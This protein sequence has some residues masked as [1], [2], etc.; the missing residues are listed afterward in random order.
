LANILVID[1]EA[2][3]VKA[4]EYNL[5]KEGYGVSRA[6]DG[7]NGLRAA[8]EKQPDLIL[9]DLMLP[10]ISGLE[11][12]KTLKADK[13]TASIPIIMLTA[14]GEEMDKVVGLE[15]GAEDYI[16]KPF[17]MRE[18]IARIK[19]V[20]KRSGRPA[21]TG[22]KLLKS[23]G[24]EL[25]SEK[26]LIS[27]AGKPVELTAK[28]FTLLQFLMESPDK[29]FGRELLLDRVWGIDQSIETRTVDVHMLRLRE[30]LGKPGKALQTIR[31]VGY[32]F[33][34]GK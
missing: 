26:H 20:L 1:D 12:C 3:I 30:K 31:G 17:G 11:L 25:D 9:L 18:L 16:T 24:I 33:S 23:G 21:E 34:P 22:K 29:V 32:R 5:K 28:E 6:F 13:K 2:D 7:I 4:I 15:V 27:S 8:R 14:K 19:T 10:G